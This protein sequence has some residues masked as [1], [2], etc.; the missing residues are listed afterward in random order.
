[1][2]IK[3]NI[4]YINNRILRE[5]YITFILPFW[6]I[7][8]TTKTNKTFFS[9][10]DLYCLMFKTV[11]MTMIFV[12]GIMLFTATSA[13]A[14]LQKQQLQQYQQQNLPANTMTSMLLSSPAASQPNFSKMNKSNSAIMTTTATA[15]PATNIQPA[16]Q[17]QQM[18]KTQ[19]NNNNMIPAFESN[20]DTNANK[21]NT[22]TTKVNTPAPV[23]AVKQNVVVQK[24]IQAS[25]PS[26]IV[27][28]DLG[29]PHK[30]TTDYGIVDLTVTLHNNTKIRSLNTTN[31]VGDHI[32]MP[33]RFSIKNDK[34]PIQLS[35]KYTACASG[36]FLDTAVCQTGI[37][38]TKS[39]PISRTNIELG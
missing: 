19:S 10:S 34:V 16:K 32:V 2:I 35:D 14:C 25:F 20:H 22:N 31:F 4:T 36:E 15:P 38:K 33:F 29:M 8:V 5:D 37:I 21:T 3:C 18:E 12:I 39:P 13:Y 7:Y 30:N 28:V 6:S 24:K 17:Q 1:M 27:L 26:L 11:P 23:Q 9:L